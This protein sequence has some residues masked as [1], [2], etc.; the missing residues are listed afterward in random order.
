MRKLIIAIVITLFVI[1]SFA[2]IYGP[3][4]SVYQNIGQQEKTEIQHYKQAK[5]HKKSRAEQIIKQLQAMQI[6]NQLALL[7][8]HQRLVITDQ[9]I[10]AINQQ[11]QT[12]MAQLQ[13]NNAA[14]QGNLQQLNQQLQS[15]QAQLQRTQQDKHYNQRAILITIIFG[16]S[17]AILLFIWSII[18]AFK[19]R[20]AI[21][22]TA[23]TK[24][25]YDF[26]SSK[27]SIP[28]KL[29]LARTYIAMED[30]KAA[31]KVLKEVIAKGNKR[32]QATADKLLKQLK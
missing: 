16:F 20:R 25:E 19:N 6:K 4:K 28:V 18:L 13:Q 17:I 2:K 3:N 27:E 14:L 15:V 31:R 9:A 26:M 12:Q 32:Q 23:D 1:P 22:A 10:T 30:K 11:Y 24:T 7:K 5:K 8:L 29:D 21:K